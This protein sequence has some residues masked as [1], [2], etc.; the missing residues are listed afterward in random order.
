M[1]GNDYRKAWLREHGEAAEMIAYGFGRELEIPVEPAP[2]APREKL[3]RKAQ[4]Q[5]AKRM[6][7]GM[8]AHGNIEGLSAL[9]AYIHSQIDAA[10]KRLGENREQ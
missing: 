2:A 8:F 9:D 6:V 10:K 3:L 4:Y 7:D 5:I 1:D